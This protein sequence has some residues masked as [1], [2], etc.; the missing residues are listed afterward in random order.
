MTYLR[1]LKAHLKMMKSSNFDLALK[2]LE[3]H[4]TTTVGH[5]VAFMH[6]YNLRFGPATTQDEKATYRTLYPILR[7]E[8]DKVFARL[9]SGGATPSA[10]GAPPPPSPGAIFQGIEDKHLGDDGKGR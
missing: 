3:N 4:K 6:A 5:L 7:G 8:R 2:D 9:S 1:N 10:A